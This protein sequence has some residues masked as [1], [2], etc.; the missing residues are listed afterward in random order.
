MQAQPTI[1]N[2]IQSWRLLA[3]IAVVALVFIVFL[4]RLFILQV[5]QNEEWT[6]KAA[7]NSADEIN[8]P[9]L[10]GLIYD[11]NGV[12]LAHN[13]ASYNVVVNASQL[14]DDPGAT[15]EIFRQLSQLIGVP[16]SQSEITLENPYV[17]CISD[18][19]ISQIA[20]YAETSTPYQPVRI[21]CDVDERLAMI[22][23]EKAVDWPGIS[24]EIQSI[25][26]YPTSSVTAAIVG[27]LGPVPAALEDFYVEKGLVPNRDKVGYAGLEL[28]YQDVLAGRNGQRLVQIDVAGQALRDISPP[29]EP[30]AG[31]SVRLT[32]DTRLQ[33]AAEQILVD[34]IE[35][36][37]AY[38][39]EQRYSS[40]VVIAMNPRT[41][42]ILSMVSYP[43]YENNRMARLIPFY[44]Y[45]QLVNDPTNPLLNH[46]VGD[47]LPAGSV[48]K[49]VTGVGA[50]NE[51]V[52]TPDQIIST[53]PKLEVTE[54]YYANDPGRAREF[55]D[56]NKAGF[57][58]LD[59][60]HGLSNSSNVYFYKLGGGFEDEVPAGLGI[61]RLG[62][63]AA[64][65][66][67]G[68]APGIG[69]PDEEDGLIPDPTWKRINQ[70]ESWS[71]G[72][73]YIASV[74]QGY[75]LATPIQ[76]LLSA[77]TVANDGKLVQPTLLRE[78]LDSNG[79]T[80]Q[81]WRN[82]DG[83]LVDQPVDG[84]FQVSPFQ[85]RL[86]WDLTVDPVIQEYGETTVRGCE[87]IPGQKKTVAP[88]VFDTMKQG[89]RLAVTEG[90]LVRQ[91]E[92]ETISA[93]GKTGT[94]EYCDKYANALNRCIPG[95]WPSH[96]WTVAFAPYENP[97]IA[98]VAYVY[99]GNEGATVAGPIVR[100]VLEAYFELKNIDSGAVPAP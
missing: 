61:C 31:R 87:P 54:K 26:E 68:S 93:A 23:L 40:G 29:I 98:V 72:D 65:M 66:G 28:Q 60:I 43:T 12:V 35:D 83:D 97:E 10:R 78:V 18:H 59:F 24:V 9:A 67:Y 94:A 82:A 58:H 22:V 62:T 91:F 38:F 33:Q 52:V 63:Y 90:T 86:K 77:A 84:A 89:M 41:G 81:M 48:F 44:Y 51:G 30:R 32:L 34:E 6:A 45:N 71:S 16:V 57:G 56:W 53:P 75:V 55:V 74:G 88:W 79:N 100:R 39:G 95:N 64:A 42:E 36:W 14:P 46:A 15:Q 5:V 96:A 70:A 99:N 80:I 27:F 20:E 13:V 11:R 47:V 4:S 19:G 2:E 8:L 92:G 76:V 21:K 7:E 37:N 25:R 1:R 17:P 49:L 3:F 73:T 85:P 50:L 69:L